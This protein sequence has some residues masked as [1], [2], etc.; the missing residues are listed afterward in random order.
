MFG[1]FHYN[2]IAL[3]VAID[4]KPPALTDV[5]K[6]SPTYYIHMNMM[7]RSLKLKLFHTIT[8][9]SSIPATQ[10]RTQ[11]L[12]NKQ[13]LVIEIPEIFWILLSKDRV[14]LTTSKPLYSS[15]Y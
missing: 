6:D 14:S 11:K 4:G 9:D 12:S 8:I 15:S 7:D 5:L 3:S 10:V 13:Q 1:Y 2:K